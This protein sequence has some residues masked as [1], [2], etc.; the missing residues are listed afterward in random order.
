MNDNKLIGTI[1]NSTRGTNIKLV[2]MDASGKIP[3][4]FAIKGNVTSVAATVV[5][6]KL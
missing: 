3:K 1:I 6:N 5:F 2:G 4:E